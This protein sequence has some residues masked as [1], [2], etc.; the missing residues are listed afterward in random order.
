MTH[1]H[2]WNSL[3]KTFHRLHSQPANDT[4]WQ[5]QFV[6]VLETMP[7][8]LTSRRH[9]PGFYTTPQWR[10]ARA[11]CLAARPVCAVIGCGRKAAH[12]DHVIARARGGAPF[13]VSNLRGRC[14]S[15]HSRKTA[16]VDGGFGNPV[17]GVER[18]LKG[19]DAD[20]NP[21]GGWGVR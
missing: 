13:A 21:L 3:P 20:G 17:G 1:T 7:P 2:L 15:C 6:S 9:D 10:A 18:G 14:W 4:D 12:V 8:M 19:A 11:A 5:L 16:S